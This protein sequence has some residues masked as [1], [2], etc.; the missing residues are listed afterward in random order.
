MG[1]PSCVFFGF[2]VDKSGTRLADKNLDP[3]KRM[4]PP[5]NLPELRMTLAVFVQSSRFIP[6]YAHIVRPLTELTRCTNGQPVPYLRTP[7]RQTSY[8]HIRNLLLD[9]I[10]LAPPDYRLPFH[11]GGDA[12]NDGKSYGIH[13]FSDLPRGT[14]FTVTAHSPTETTV[15]LTDSNTS[16]TIPHNSNT[17]L[18][19][20]WFSKTWS[21]ANRK[22]A[23][24]YLEADTPLWG[25]AKCRFWAL[26]SPF[27]LYAS[28]DHMPI[29][30]IRKLSEFTIEQLS[31]IQWVL[32][33]IPGKK[34]P[35]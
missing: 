23:P 25:L 1:F 4:V 33:Y 29:K 21:E 31:D 9:G 22:R 7:D 19:I 27:L 3:I 34:L 26:S 14:N 32:S 13:Q 18:N 35:F 10:H 20:A 24:F 16:H 12:S 5:S 2:H 15:C 17:R 11:S 6:R 28:S 30:W 8:D